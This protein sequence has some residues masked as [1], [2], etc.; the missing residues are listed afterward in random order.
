[1]SACP[2][3]KDPAVSVPAVRDLARRL[4]AQGASPGL[5][6]RVLARV[7]TLGRSEKDAH[8]LDL[9]ARVIGGS[10]PR[11][12][13]RA[14]RSGPAVLSVVG[15]RG[16][17]RSAFARKLALRLCGAGR[18]VAV[19]AVAQRGSSRPEWLATWMNEIGAFACVVDARDEIPRR[20]L[21][22]KDV[23]LIDGS[24]ELE[25][26]AAIAARVVLGDSSRRLVE[27]RMGVLAADMS[28]ERLRADARALR[29]SAAGCSVLTRLDLAESPAAA[30]EIVCTA[31][32]PLAFVSD[33]IEEEKH[34]HR[35][36][37]ERAADLF[38]TGRVA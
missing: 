11:V 25:R 32:L 7:E 16:C 3:S 13:M 23:V 29:A 22:E 20:A 12:T 31:G 35:S 2:Q 9:G 30:L 37:P 21:E 8:P 15:S 34:L 6:Q 33:G 5:T 28:P 17:G 1:M 24:G 38:L 10:F 26:D 4:L 27:M 18:R 14:P 36:G 19:L